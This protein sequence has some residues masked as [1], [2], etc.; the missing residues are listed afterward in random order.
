MDQLLSRPTLAAAFWRAS[1]LEAAVY[2]ERLSSTGRRT[3]IGR[4]TYFATSWRTAKSLVSKRLGCTFHRSTSPPQALLSCASI[5]RSRHCGSRTCC[6][7]PTMPS[8]R[9]AGS[10][11]RKW[12]SSTAAISICRSLSQSG[13]Y[14]SRKPPTGGE[15]EEDHFGVPNANT[16]A[17]CAE[18]KRASTRVGKSFVDRWS[19]SRSSPRQ[20]SQMNGPAAPARLFTRTK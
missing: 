16:A 12:P 13:P 17:F 19:T 2:R 1:M 14:R 3:A 20:T 10:N 6:P 9:S 8:R 4:G 7:R 18:L 11:S 5:A 15:T